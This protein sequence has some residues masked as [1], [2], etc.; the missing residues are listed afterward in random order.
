MCEDAIECAQAVARDHHVRS[1]SIVSRTLPD[2][3]RPGG[4]SASRKR[5]GELRLQDLVHWRVLRDMA[6]SSG[7]ATIRLNARGAAETAGG[8][9]WRIPARRAL[10]RRAPRFDGQAA[11][12]PRSGRILERSGWSDAR[13]GARR[14][15]DVVMTTGPRSLVCAHSGADRGAL[16]S[17]PGTCALV[18]GDEVRPHIGTSDAAAA[19]ATSDGHKSR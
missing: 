6:D 5:V 8:R 18:F 9:R 7:G 1:P 3:A 12:L 2:R 17:H 13:R 19:V 10:G 15:L 11:K 4:K 16:L 14:L